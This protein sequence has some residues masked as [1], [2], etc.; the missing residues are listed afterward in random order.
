MWS[1]ITRTEDSMRKGILVLFGVGV[2]ALAACA[3]DR[4]SGTATVI[5]GEDADVFDA[6]ASLPDIGSDGGLDAIGDSVSDSI[7]SGDS[8]EDVALTDADQPDTFDAVDEPDSG[9]VIPD[10]AGADWLCDREAR[11]A[12]CDSP[13]IELSTPP[14]DGDD[15]LF[16]VNRASPLPAAYPIAADTVWTPCDG[17]TVAVEHDL[18]CVPEQY[19]SGPRRALRQL[20]WESPAPDDYPTTHDGLTVGDDGQIGYLAMF[21]A[22]EAEADIELFVVSGFRSYRTQQVLHESYVDREMGNGFTEEEARL[23]AATYSARPGHSEHQLGTTADL[24][25]RTDGG[26]V[27]DGLDQVMGASRAF[28]W[29]FRNAHRFGIVLTYDVHRVETT[30]YVYE[31]WHYRF[32][33]VEAA[34]AMRRCQL[35]TEEFLAARYGAGE[36]PPWGGE[37]YTLDWNARMERQLTVPDGVTLLPGTEV[38]RTWQLAN[39]GSTNWWNYPVVQTAGPELDVD[40]AAAICVLAG[41]SGEVGLTFRAPSTLGEYVTEWSVARPDGEPFGPG[42]SLRFT[43]ADTLPTGVNYAWVRVRDLSDA[44]GGADPG[45]DID[46]VGIDDDG[47]F[48]WADRTDAYIARPSSV[49]HDIATDATGEPDAYYNWPDVDVCGVNAGFVSLGGAGEVV[50]HMPRAVRE[51]DVLEVL[52]VGDCEYS[53]GSFAIADDIEVAVAGSASG[54]WVVVGVGGA[55]RVRATVPALEGAP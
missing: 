13:L 23:V 31:P 55:P 42:L 7:D 36:L 52:E 24:T 41:S 5:D 3:D 46:A 35:D 15:L 37:P 27:F 51:G 39:T 34:D 18:I 12:A 40:P 38:T 20:A 44:T 25:Y 4:K 47:A 50:V 21:R 43:V 32:V 2:A 11:A 53:P 1:S 19:N 10:G 14:T 22:A 8:G 9:D 26:S 54:P 33:G 45:A 16:Y 17:G 49:N 29:V 28:R 48:V 30:Q 6:D